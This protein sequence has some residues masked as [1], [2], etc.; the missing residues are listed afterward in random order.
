MPNMR[1]RGLRSDGSGDASGRKAVGGRARRRTAEHRFEPPK[2][3]NILPIALVAAAVV[4]L[5]GVWYLVGWSGDRAYWV[6]FCQLNHW[7]ASQTQG[8][9]PQQARERYRKLPIGKVSD[10]ML[11]EMHALYGKVLDASEEPR[12]QFERVDPTDP[13]SWA[14]MEARSKARRAYLERMDRKYG[15]L[16]KRFMELTDKAL[17]KYGPVPNPYR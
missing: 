11:K 15:P 6:A 9:T 5:A 7:V 3:T 8:A 12:P 13:D 14:K 16:R 2:K 10:P 17:N 4:V 1:R